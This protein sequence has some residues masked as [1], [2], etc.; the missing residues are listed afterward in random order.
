ML[1]FYSIRSGNAFFVNP[2]K[3]RKKLKSS[4][5]NRASDLQQDL[6]SA[7]NDYKNADKAHSISVRQAASKHGV[8]VTSLW[9][10]LKNNDSDDGTK[11]S[12][13]ES[14]HDDGKKQP[15]RVHQQMLL[16]H[17]EEQQ[18]VQWINTQNEAKIP[19]SRREIALQIGRMFQSRNPPEKLRKFP[20][21][22]WFLRF[23]DRHNLSL[24]QSRPIETARVKA[25]TQEVITAVNVM[26]RISV[27]LILA[28]FSIECGHTFPEFQ[29]VT[30]RL[31]GAS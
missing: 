8:P 13:V 14:E 2:M 5:S 28:T 1:D 29:E 20:S 31:K 27:L 16:T 17:V 22:R 11:L 6:E 19:P 30:G 18:L 9:R 25:I 23:Q 15:P 10:M 7:Y 12:K 26:C 24:R 4:S 3:K 21:A